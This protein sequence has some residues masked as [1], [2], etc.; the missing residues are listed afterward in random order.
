MANTGYLLF[1]GS[2]RNE[3]IKELVNGFVVWATLK[4]P[5][6]LKNIHI[7]YEMECPSVV[8]IACD[9]ITDKIGQEF[10]DARYNHQLPKVFEYVKGF[11]CDSTWSSGWK[12]LTHSN[13][14]NG[15]DNYKPGDTMG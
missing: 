9:R 12:E 13:M 7:R 6:H 3:N 8:C 4:Y 5:D 14:T 15:W 2:H 1:L 10:W 11:V